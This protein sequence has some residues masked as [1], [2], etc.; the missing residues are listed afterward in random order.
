[1]IIGMIAVTVM[2]TVVMV[3]R[4][5]RNLLRDE[6]YLMHTLPVS[7]HSLVWSK[8][9]V[10]LCWFAVTFLV[11]LLTMLLT[12]LIQSG[13][14]L[15]EFFAGFPSWAEIQAALEQVGIRI[16]DLWLLGGE[17]LLGVKA[18]GVVVKGAALSADPWKATNIGLMQ[19]FG[20]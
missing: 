18:E 14:S 7:V 17:Y 20:Y 3:L 12:G 15:G 11:I 2:T 1:M 19:Q 13:A 8:L 5:Y 9:I 10:S 6:G 4:F 16:G